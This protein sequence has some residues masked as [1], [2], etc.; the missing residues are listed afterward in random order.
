MLWNYLASRREDLERQSLCWL[1][2]SIVNSLWS[3][4]F[5][6]HARIMTANVC[7]L[8]WDKYWLNCKMPSC[9]KS[10]KY[11][12]SFDQNIRYVND[13][14]Q[15]TKKSKI[16]KS[17]VLK[18]LSCLYFSCWLAFLQHVWLAT[19][20]WLTGTHSTGVDPSLSSQTFHLKLVRFANERNTAE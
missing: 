11:V 3:V 4:M 18:S 1:Q 7:E 9:S 17:G 10:M 20:S 19:E 6:R 12:T 8:T 13:L 16:S 2:R 14:S 5:D 15:W